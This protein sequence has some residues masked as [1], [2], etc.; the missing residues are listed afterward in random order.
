MLTGIGGS[1]KSALAGRAM[2]RLAEEGWLVAACVGRFDL[3]ECAMAIGMALSQSGRAKS[4][5][6][7]MLL[8]PGLDDRIRFELLTQILETDG[9]FSYWMIS[10]R[11][12]TWAA[13]VSGP[14][15]GGAPD[16]AC[17]RRAHG[18][19]LLTCRYPVPGTESHLNRVPIG[20]LSAAEIR[21][22]IFRLPALREASAPEL[23]R[24]LSAIGGHPRLLEFLDASNEWWPRASASRHRKASHHRATARTRSGRERRSTI[25]RRALRRAARHCAAGGRT[26]CILDR[27]LNI[28]AGG[29][30]RRAALQA[31]CSNLPV[32]PAGLARMLAGGEDPGDLAFARRAIARLEALSIAV[33]MPEGEVWVHRWT[34]QGLAELFGREAHQARFGRAG[35]YRWW[36]VRN[37]SSSIVDGIEALRNF[38]GWPGLRFRRDGSAELP[39]SSGPSQ[40]VRTGRRPCCRSTR[41]VSGLARGYPSIADAEGKARLALGQSD[42]AL[43]RYEVLLQRGRRLAQAEPDRA[44]YQRDLSVCYEQRGGPV[45][46][47]G[48]GRAGARSPTCSRWPFAERLAQAEPDR[49]DYQRDLSV[50]YDRMGDLYRASGQGEQAR[51]VLSAVAGHRERLA[52]AEPDRADYQRDLSVSYNKMGDLYRDLGQGE[53]ARAVLRAVAGHCRTAGAGRAGSRRLPARPVGLVQQGGRPV[54]RSGPGRGGAAVVRESLAIAERLA[55][56]EPDRA[57]YQRDLSV[58]Y[59]R[60]ATCTARWAR[61]SRRASPTCSRWRLRSGWRR[62]SRIAPTISA[63]SGSAYGK[64]G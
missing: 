44:D 46:R 36:R 47:A 55:R 24:V 40:A 12:S 59:N 14:G 4:S 41:D 33:G 63:A 31:G 34:A 58:S 30:D 35:R 8:Q 23:S 22:M 38:S 6:T 10:S 57:D 49:A 17:P 27:V 1:G 37:E 60:W 32:P 42:R 28:C 7:D 20:P 15:C 54:P 45:P 48:P 11:T 52:R 53:E 62:P 9:W 2:Q 19:V 29:R 25:E 51:A 50:S 26:G 39:G 16:G 64:S 43:R 56:A 18:A 21:K 61:A 13:A 3:T 5:V